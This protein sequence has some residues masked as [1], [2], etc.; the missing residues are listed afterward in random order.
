MNALSILSFVGLTA[1]I[2]WAAGPANEPAKI[3]SEKE[4]RTLSMVYEGDK[5]FAA[6]MGVMPNVTERVTNEATEGC[7][8]AWTQTVTLS[9]PETTTFS[10]TVLGSDQAIAA[11][12]RGE[13]QKRFPLIRTSHG[14]SQNLRNNAIYDRQQ[15]W[16]LEVPEGSKI[17]TVRKPDGTFRFDLTLTGK[18]LTLTFRP[19][20]YQR[21]KGLAYYEPWTYNVYQGSI[22]GWSS[23]WAYMR[24]CKE[25]D[26]DRLLA[27]WEKYHFADYGYKFIQLDDVFQ[28]EHDRDKQHNPICAG[29]RGGNPSTWLDWRKD[30]FPGG[31]NHFVSSTQKAGFKPAL[32]I[33]CCYS[34]ADVAKAHPE[35][36]VTDAN[37]KPHHTPWVGY[38]LNPTDPAIADTFIRPIYRGLRQA[39]I[40][41]VKIDQLRHMYYDGLNHTPEWLKQHGLT[42][43]QVQRAYLKI[44]RE[45][46]GKNAFI[47]SCWG[48]NPA[49][50]GLADACRIG[51]DGYGPVTLQQYNSWNGL[52]WRN[53]PDHCDIKPDKQ[54]AEVGNVKKT[55]TRSSVKADT[56]VRPA[57]AS[58][59]GAMLLL[60]DRPEI[61]ENPQNT[62]GLKRVS[63]VVFTVPGQLY[64]FDPRKS[65]WLKSHTQAD[66]KGGAYPTPFDGDQFGDVCPYWLNEFDTNFDHWSVLHRLNWPQKASP[67]LPAKTIAFADLGLK[68]NAEYLVYDFWSDK[69]LGVCKESFSLP[70]LASNSIESWAIR[71]VQGR[72]QLLSTNRH[73]SQGCVDVEQLWWESEKTLSGRSRAIQEEPYTLTFYLPNGTTLASATFDG[74]PAQ[75]T[76]EGN[77]LRLSVT[78]EKAASYAWSLTFR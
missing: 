6:M 45:E 18:S 38:I 32:W 29:Y 63:P 3:L 46:L 73:L 30:L 69:F 66:V 74:K 64:D 34:Y 52:V 13:A 17:T 44:A 22:T 62:Y 57:L 19:R 14:P 26:V 61:Y 1:T 23:W 54:A 58:I 72:P 75:T 51:G 67:A 56:I 8:P 43:D 37:G 59:A 68:P 48:V 5:F 4:P 70:E 11:E 21:H 78:P 10:A 20:Y 53:D 9:F 77:L 25:A 15:D 60:S 12:T 55:A 27:V 31:L 2:S 41:Y 42:A 39:G 76:Q 28:G 49:A 36:F 16:M 7:E 24:N 65:D 47:L 33:S 40:D 50:I 35:W 71:E